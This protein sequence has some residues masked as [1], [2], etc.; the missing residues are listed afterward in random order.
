MYYAKLGWRLENYVTQR[1]SFLPIIKNWPEPEY[2]RPEKKQGVSVQPSTLLPSA[3]PWRGL[4]L[5]LV[6]SCHTLIYLAGD[7]LALST[8]ANSSTWRGLL[9]LGM[10]H[11]GIPCTSIPHGVEPAEVGLFLKIVYL[12]PASVKLACP[13]VTWVSTGSARLPS[14]RRVTRYLP[15]SLY[16]VLATSAGCACEDGARWCGNAKGIARIVIG[17]HLFPSSSLYL[18]HMPY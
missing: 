10:G 1:L 14:R 17:C 13:T 3:S 2:D 7:H 9:Q 15:S 5:I 18:S 16:A 12:R 4:W 6:G 11:G 8:R